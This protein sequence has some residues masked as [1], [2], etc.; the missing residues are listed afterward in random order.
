MALKFRWLTLFSASVKLPPLRI[1]QGKH[2]RHEKLKNMPKLRSNLKTNLPSRRRVL[3]WDKGHSQSPPVI[4][5][6]YSKPSNKANVIVSRESQIS[7]A[8]NRVE[9][10]WSVFVKCSLLSL[11][12]IGLWL[13]KWGFSFFWAEKSLGLAPE[14]TLSAALKRAPLYSL[15]ELE[16]FREA[17]AA[18]KARKTDSFAALAGRAGLSNYDTSQLGLMLGFKDF[19]KDK[20]KPGQLFS[21]TY[22]PKG[23]VLSL[24]TEKEPGKKLIFDRNSDGEFVTDGHIVKPPKAEK[25]AVGIIETSFSAAA[26]K[27]GVRYDLID[28]LVDLFSDRVEFRKDFHKGD[29]FTLIYREGLKG[30]DNQTDS[31]QI[32]GAALEVNGEHLVAARYIGTDG[33]ARYFNEKGQLLG[34]A[35]LRYPVKFSR[36]SSLFTQSRFHPVLK[37][38]RPHNGVDFAAPIGTPVRTVADGVVQ[39]AGPNGGSG[40]MVKIRHGDRYSTV[41]LHLSSIAKGIVR[42]S[43]VR[44]GDL[45]GAVGMTGLATGP[46]LHFGFY[47]NDR[48]IDPLSVKLPTI[49]SLDP[50]TKMNAEY[51][52]RVLFTLEH[53][54][55]VKLE[56]VFES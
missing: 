23:E 7:R 12:L 46:H 30:K 22:G 35:F 1:S 56:E 18:L 39:F 2:S 43:K 48:Y 54:Q 36:I 13:V 55:S 51:L 34:N 10:L 49:D 15:P 31:A 5:R 25:V 20:L 40:T 28:D 47:D 17:S 8:I 14:S 53:Y 41:Y 37:F 29:R 21:F 45:I 6:K 38:A 19:K 24:L 42:G 3:V 50:G 33:K 32:I 16:P 26:S 4:L 52:K 44:R 9:L 27:S 11:A